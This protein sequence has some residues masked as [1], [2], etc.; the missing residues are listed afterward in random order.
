MINTN[1]TP[2]ERHIQS[3]FQQWRAHQ[4]AARCFF[5]GFLFIPCIRLLKVFH[6][7]IY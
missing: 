4:G 2:E 3:L 5:S 1:L 6:E 7:R